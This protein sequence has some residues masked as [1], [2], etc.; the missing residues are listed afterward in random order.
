V[1]VRAKYRARLDGAAASAGGFGDE[2]AE[3]EAGG[4][5][6]FAS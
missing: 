2:E 3:A 5:G 1:R 6:H 4:P